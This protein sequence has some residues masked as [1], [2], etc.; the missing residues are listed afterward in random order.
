MKKQIHKKSNRTSLK[1]EKSSKQVKSP[2]SI[3]TTSDS[4]RAYF[5]SKKPKLP[6]KVEEESEKERFMKKYGEV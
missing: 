2:S 6:K 5:K 1:S 3:P 4:D